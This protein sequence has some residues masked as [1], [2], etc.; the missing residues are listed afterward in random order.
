LWWTTS[1]RA[2]G[3]L[4]QN[5]DAADGGWDGRLCAAVGLDRARFVEFVASTGPDYSTLEQWVQTIAVDISPD[6]IAAS[7]QP[8]PP[9]RSSNSNCT[10]GPMR[11]RNWASSGAHRAVDQQ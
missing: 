6:T 9:R 7:T 11:M 8:F 1:L 4:P 2:A 5:E 3:R 10:I